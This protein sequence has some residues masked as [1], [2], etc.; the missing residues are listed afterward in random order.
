MTTLDN[1]YCRPTTEAEWDLLPDRD[2]WCRNEDA[3]FGAIDFSKQKVSNKT[4]IHVQHFI[5]LIEDRI[6]AWRL[7][8]VGFVNKYDSDYVYSIDNRTDLYIM[9]NYNFIRS[10][11]NSD[12][13]DIP[14][15]IKTFTDL[16]TLIRFL[17]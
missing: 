17:K 4:E 6:C 3:V 2:L 16:L 7:E 5:D 11:Y 15:N 1:A 12:E 9:L 8:E 14:V 13:V 10:R